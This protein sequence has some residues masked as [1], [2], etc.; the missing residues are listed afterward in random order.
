MLL[1]PPVACGAPPSFETWRAGQPEAVL[2][3]VDSPQRLTG[4]V[5]PTG[6][7]K[8]LVASTI[9][10]LTGWRTAILTSTKGLQDQVE[11]TFRPTGIKDVRGQRAYPCRLLE[12]DVRR[13][14]EGGTTGCDLGPCKVGTVCHW[15]ERGCMYF[16]AVG[17][18]TRARLVVTNYQAWMSHYAYGQGL[19]PFDC[20]VLDE[21]HAAPEELSSFLSSTIT[22]H[23]LASAGL[24]PP[25]LPLIA[26]WCAWAR[27]HK[28]DITTWVQ[29]VAREGRVAS[30]QWARNLLTTVE[31]LALADPADWLVLPHR[32]SFEFHPLDPG[33]YT[34]A[35]LLRGI[36]RVVLMSAT[37]TP[38][39]VAALG[40]DPATVD[41]HTTPSTFP[42]ERRPIVYVP[43][44]RLDH[45]LD[46]AGTRLWL[47]R[48]DQI[49]AAR[50]DR[51][52]IIHTGS[53]ARA[54]LI[55]EHSDHRARLLFHERDTTRQTV[56]AFRR[57]A[58]TT[59]MVSPSLT[60]GFDFPGTTCEFQIILKVPWPDARE[61]VMQARTAK[62][63]AYPA[64]LAMQDL[65]QAVGRGMRSAEDRCETLILDDH[66][67]WFLSSYRHYAPRWF[68]EA[69]R[70][71]LTIPPAPPRL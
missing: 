7:G 22:A 57:S 2:H 17:D 52:G 66:C 19:G 32:G 68:L 5:L 21:A 9:A 1:P 43:T 51:K 40:L 11:Q 41:F 47:T 54:K 67:K 30:V 62:D 31:R 20:L 48:V 38:K 4:L 23:Q 3:V 35:T 8:S 10:T 56:E 53:Y 71:S 27:A 37:M 49:L 59:V 45:R 28:R 33:T 13:F 46:D 14:H 69:Y 24:E 55:Y 65:V 50:P 25:P 42:V 29:T 6:S 12:P 36:P 34:E 61:P 58:R 16:D 44:C 15:R 63:K 64:Y 60:T 39:T 70:S 26:D 18:A